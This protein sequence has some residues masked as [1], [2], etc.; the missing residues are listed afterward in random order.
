MKK[1][2]RE[3]K[4]KKKNAK[5]KSKKSTEVKNTPKKFFLRGKLTQKKKI[6]EEIVQKTMTKQSGGGEKIQGSLI[7]G[8]CGNM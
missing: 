2:V 4:Q 6:R 7:E 3:K 1:R 5:K 8:G